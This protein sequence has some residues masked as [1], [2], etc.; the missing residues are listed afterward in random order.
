MS[1]RHYTARP[2]T[3]IGSCEARRLAPVDEARVIKAL[4]RQRAEQAARKTTPVVRP[5]RDAAAAGLL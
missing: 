3:A 1:A 5:L 2:L 4:A